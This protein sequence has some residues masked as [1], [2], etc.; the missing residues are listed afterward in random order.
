MTIE[1]KEKKID[2]YNELKYD[3]PNVWEGQVKKVITVPGVIG[4]LGCF[5]KYWEKKFANIG[6]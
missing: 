2:N 4:A 6:L 1:H 3:I 5:Q